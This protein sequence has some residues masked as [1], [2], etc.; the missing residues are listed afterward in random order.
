MAETLA[1][2]AQDAGLVV[3][4]HGGQA[5][6]RGGDLILIG[7]P[8]IITEDEISELMSRLR[9]ALDATLERIRDRS[10]R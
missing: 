10:R 7:P 1:E 8:F 3:W 4:P 5:D 2:T 6:G 9:M